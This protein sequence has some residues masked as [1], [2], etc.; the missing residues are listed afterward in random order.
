MLL[1][2]KPGGVEEKR[3]TERQSKIKRQ[4]DRDRKIQRETGGEE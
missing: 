3:Q 4:K 1:T 2:G